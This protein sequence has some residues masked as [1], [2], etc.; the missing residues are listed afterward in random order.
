[1]KV[2]MVE[3]G[4]EPYEKEIENTLAAMQEAIGGYIEVVYTKDGDAILLNEEGKLLGLPPN[5]SFYNDI[6]AGTFFIA[7]VEDEDFASLS[8]E[9]LTYYTDMFKEPLLDYS[10]DTQDDESWEYEL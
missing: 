4:R 3:P 8:D 5:R 9:K 7:G 6:F 2:L 10:N 1:M